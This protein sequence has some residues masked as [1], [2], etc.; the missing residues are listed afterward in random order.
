MKKKRNILCR[1]LIQIL[2]VLRIELA[3]TYCQWSFFCLSF[4]A[5]TKKSICYCQKPLGKL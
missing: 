2:N 5:Y 1:L 3:F 4:I